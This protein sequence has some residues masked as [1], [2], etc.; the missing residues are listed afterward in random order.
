MWYCLKNDKSYPHAEHHKRTAHN[1]LER[2]HAYATDGPGL[3]RFERLGVSYAFAEFLVHVL[4]S[5]TDAQELLADVIKSTTEDID[6]HPAQPPDPSLLG[7]IRE[8]L[9]VLDSF[10]REP[11]TGDSRLPRKDT[12]YTPLD[13]VHTSRK[14]FVW[15]ASY[16]VLSV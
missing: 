2:I 5:P 3:E 10:L 13:H 12:H 7:V 1:T 4:N 11:Q 14:F 8:I 9:L 15:P 16:V 6:S